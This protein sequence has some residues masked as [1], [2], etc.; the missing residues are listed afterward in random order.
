MSLR[1]Y[2]KPLPS[3]LL[4]NQ[5][6]DV[7]HTSTPPPLTRKLS[8]EQFCRQKLQGRAAP[9]VG[10]QRTRGLPGP[11][12]LPGPRCP[13]P[14]VRAQTWQAQRGGQEVS[15]AGGHGRVGI[16]GDGLAQL[17]ALGALGDQVGG[18]VPPVDELKLLD[19]GQG[20]QGGGGRWSQ[21][22]RTGCR[23][24]SATGVPQAQGRCHLCPRL[25]KPQANPNLPGSLPFDL[26]S[27]PPAPPNHPPERHSVPGSDPG[28]R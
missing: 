11:C 17:L 10:E 2:G 19:L 5:C 15:G 6:C 22:R 18:A 1:R 21:L 4:R 25:A 23:A 8:G 27:W 12:P 14:L 3:A 20:E 26:P 9:F 24:A 13:P 16:R 7:S 28:Q